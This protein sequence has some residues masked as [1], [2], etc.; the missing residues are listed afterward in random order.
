MGFQEG[1]LNFR[2]TY[3]RNRDTN[4]GWSRKKDQAPSWCDRIL[5][6]LKTGRKIEVL[7]YQGIEA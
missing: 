3:R 6:K 2:P 5:Y 7:K 1:E 4:E